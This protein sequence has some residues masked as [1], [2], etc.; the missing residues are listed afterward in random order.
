[1]GGD[2]HKLGDTTIDSG[3]SRVILGIETQFDL[4]QL[5]ISRLAGSLPEGEVQAPG[6]EARCDNLQL[7][8]RRARRAMTLSDPHLA[9][10]WDRPRRLGPPVGHSAA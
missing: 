5:T 3:Q 1:V 6:R 4:G 9:R 8:P 7:A 2:D 10:I